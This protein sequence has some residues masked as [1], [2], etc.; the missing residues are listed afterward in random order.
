LI[1]IE[2]KKSN[3]CNGDYSLY[4]TFPYDQNIV[5]IIREQVIRYWLPDTKEWE[6]PLKSFDNLKEQLKDYKLNIVDLDEKLSNFNF[7]R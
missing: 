5:N 2:V 6:L 7:N 4:I 1:N 3:K